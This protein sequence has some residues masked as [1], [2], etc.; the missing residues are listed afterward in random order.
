MP[1]GSKHRIDE[2]GVETVRSG[3]NPEPDVRQPLFEGYRMTV[4]HLAAARTSGYEIIGR[5][6][7]KRNPI[8]FSDRK[9]IRSFFS[10]TIASSAARERPVHA[11]QDRASGSRRIPYK[12][13]F[14]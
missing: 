10:S 4:M 3:R 9:R 6:A 11:A 13:A 14:S 1:A 8:R 7:E 2:P 12:R 5:L